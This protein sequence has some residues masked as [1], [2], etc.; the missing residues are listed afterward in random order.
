MNKIEYAVSV[1]KKYHFHQTR[2]SGEP[3]YMHPIS[4]ALIVLD[5]IKSGNATI[6]NML[7]ENKEELILA[8]LLHD[9]LE[10]TSYSKRALSR[11]FGVKVRDMVLAVTKIDQSN[12]SAMLSNVQAFKYLM[13]KEPLSLCIKLVDRMHNILTIDGH[14]NTGK[15][16]A[17]ARETLDFF[18]YP[19]QKFGF[20]KMAEDFKNMGKYIMENGKLD[21]YGDV[22]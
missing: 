18:Y 11:N 19:A 3:Y 20:L 22:K 10:D 7:N 6:H 8:A 13:E 5:I 16:R 14:P 12:R 9:I 17:I 4:V 21:G 15:R 1:I 2:K